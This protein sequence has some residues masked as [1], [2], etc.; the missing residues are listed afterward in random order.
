MCSCNWGQHPMMVPEESIIDMARPRSLIG[1]QPAIPLDADGKKLP[2]PIPN[3]KRMRIIDN[4]DQAKPVKTVKMD[5]AS[6]AVIMIFRKPN[7]SASHPPGICMMAYPAKKLL[8]T[9]PVSDALKCKSFEIPK[10]A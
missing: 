10:I 3:R 4:K 6:K 5:H 7:R 8:N 9:I 2:S 1:N